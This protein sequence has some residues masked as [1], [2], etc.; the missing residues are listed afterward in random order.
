[1]RM[2]SENDWVGLSEWRKIEI[3][4]DTLY[5]ETFGEWRDSTKARIKHLGRNKIALQFPNEILDKKSF[6]IYT[7]ERIKSDFEIE[8]SEVFWTQ[9]KNRKNAMECNSLK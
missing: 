6:T 4:N 8:D 9:F 7:M 2:A 1:M 3:L 5:F